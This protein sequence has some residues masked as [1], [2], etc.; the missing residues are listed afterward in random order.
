MYNG[1]GT[2]E[3]ST[4]VPQKIKNRNVIQ[5]VNHLPSMWEVL[6]STSSTEEKKNRI[7]KI[8]LKDIWIFI[9]KN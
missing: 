6:G 4:E 1:V 5:V 9:E 8:F 7:I 3:N 2:K